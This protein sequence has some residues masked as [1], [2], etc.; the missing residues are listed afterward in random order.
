MID[1]KAEI[2]A[3]ILDHKTNLKI[4]DL[5]EDS[6]AELNKKEGVSSSNNSLGCSL[7]HRATPDSK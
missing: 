3:S 1:I 7:T 5:H 2:L 6:K 4:E